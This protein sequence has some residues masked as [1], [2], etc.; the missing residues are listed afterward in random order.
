MRRIRVE[1]TS[2]V[3]AE[4]LDRLLRGKRP[5][6]E[7]LL[8]T[9]EGVYLDVGAERLDRALRCEDQAEDHRHRQQDGERGARDVDV[10]V[11]E[12]LDLAADATADQ[13]QGQ[14]AA[15]RG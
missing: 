9:F 4:V 5:D 13:D 12:R 15:R 14:R 8:S 10:A 11:A 6:S 1:R 7:H 3:I 2:A